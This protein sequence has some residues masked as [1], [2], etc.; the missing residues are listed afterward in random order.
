[1]LVY[2]DCT[3][4]LLFSS[5]CINS[6]QLH[7]FVSGEEKSLC[8]YILP[9]PLTSNAICVLINHIETFENWSSIYTF[10][11]HIILSLYLIGSQ[12]LRT[13]IKY[14]KVKTD[15]LIEIR[16]KEKKK[17]LNE[18]LQLIPLYSSIIP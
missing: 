11:V 15:P 17:K 6:Y 12:L 10:T 5:T 14:I 13:G 3:N 8:I 2:P 4:L 9:D 7:F 1:M 16:K 18:Q